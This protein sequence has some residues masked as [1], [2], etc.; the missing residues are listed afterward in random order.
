MLRIW[1][2]LLLSIL[3]LCCCQ[4]SSVPRASEAPVADWRWDNIN[5]YGRSLNAGRPHVIEI[6]AG[7]YTPGTQPFGVGERLRAFRLL[8]DEYERLHPEVTIEFVPQLIVEGGAEGEAIRTKLLGGIAPEIVNMNTEAVW[9]DVEQRKGWWLPLD[10]YLNQPNPYVPNNKAWIDVFKNRAL[11]QAKRAP[12]G[13]LY[14]ITFDVVETGIFYNKTLFEKYEATLPQTWPQFIQL[15]E[16][17]AAAGLI[18]MV[19]DRVAPMDWGPDLLFDQCYFELLGL[20]DYQKK[21]DIE[22]AYYQGYLMPEELC[23]L[24]KKGWFAAQ[25]SRFRESWR[26]LK[27]WRQFWQKDLTH[28]DQPRLFITQRSPMLWTGSWFVRRMLRD[29]LIQFDW[30]IFYLPA[31][32]RSYS[33]FCTGVDQCVIG[34]AGTQF[35]VTRRA[36]SDGDLEPTIDFLRFITTPDHASQI[37]N[38]A[39]MFIANIVDAQLPQ[40]LAPFAEIIMRRYCTIKWHYSLGHRF[41]D[42]RERLI[43]LFLND[44]LSLDEF[45][46]EFDQFLRQTAVPMIEANGWPEPD[47]IPAWSPQVEDAWRRSQRGGND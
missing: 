32:P 43:E 7:A 8:A 4:R 36:I 30:G 39:G 47:S 44:G 46:V 17:F 5:D 33:A 42:H 23:W 10:E 28:S 1:S 24:A 2:L 45:M 14:C 18:P 20:L 25:S 40:A 9:P 31:I 29:P 15:Q 11:T 27:E 41:T 37:V 22:E 35:H 6:Y 16:K 34:G 26:L 3:P 19:V 38:E 13:L 12:D 21:S